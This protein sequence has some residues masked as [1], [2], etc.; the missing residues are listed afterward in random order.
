MSENDEDRVVSLDEQRENADEQAAAKLLE[1]IKES[2]TTVF[3]HK[4]GTILDAIRAPATL[5]SVA[6]VPAVTAGALGVAVRDLQP[7][8]AASGL[9]GRCAGVAGVCLCR[10]SRR[11]KR[12][13]C[14]AGNVCTA[15]TRITNCCRWR[16]GSRRAPRGGAAN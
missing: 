2:N 3:R 14:R 5:Q 9:P 15:S 12:Q 13:S 1:I 7:N 10:R 8:T 16:C 11:H 6:G 4:L